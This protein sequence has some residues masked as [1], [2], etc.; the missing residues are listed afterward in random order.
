MSFHVD[1]GILAEFCTAATELFGKDGSQDI[2]VMLCD[3]K[4]GSLLHRDIIRMDSLS[5]FVG[6]LKSEWLVDYLREDSVESVFHPMVNPRTGR[7]EAYEC[8]MRGVLPNGEVKQPSEMISSARSTG[9]LLHLDR[10]ARISAIRNAAKEKVRETIFINFNPSTTCD[11]ELCLRS[12]VTAAESAGISPSRI[13]FEVTESEFVTDSDHLKKILSYYRSHG[14]RIALDD[15]GSGYSG[16]SLLTELKPDFVKL[17]MS[18]IRKIDTDLYKQQVTRS[19]LEMA[20]RVGVRTVVEGVE[21]HAEWSWTA[22]HGA[23]MIQGYYFAKPAFIP[24]RGPDITN[25]RADSKATYLY[26]A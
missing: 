1:S 14:F 26:S 5:Q 13:V 21:T 17:D 12:T 4:T 20:T 23:D 7:I 3:G 15:L 19:I 25:W 22:E 8:L 9:L 2:R 16:L 18:L 24:P 6:R 11:P 10:I